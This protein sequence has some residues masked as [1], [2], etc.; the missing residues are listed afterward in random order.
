MGGAIYSDNADNISFHGD[1]IAG[2]RCTA[3]FGGIVVRNGSDGWNL[4]GD[5]NP[6]DGPVKPHV[7]IF[8]NEGCQIYNDNPFSGSYGFAD[9][10]NVDARYVFWG[11]TDDAQVKQG[12]YDFF[13][14]AAKGVVFYSPTAQAAALSVISKPLNGVSI[15]GDRPGTT[16]Y[17]AICDIGDPVSLTAPPAIEPCPVTLDFER[18]VID[19][20]PQ[21][22]GQLDASVV[23]NANHLL[24]ARYRLFADA[25]GDCKVNV[26]DLIAIRNKLGQNPGTEENWAVDI[27]RD[28]RITILDLIVARNNLGVACPEE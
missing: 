18:W 24:D 17:Y 23:M 6:T 27:N 12:I 2:N 21:P 8:D 20:T 11:T 4:R 16:T 15:A 1:L 25:N 26:L 19:G 10:G 22:R 5:S 7:S 28:R 9:P 14:N 13:D 3:G